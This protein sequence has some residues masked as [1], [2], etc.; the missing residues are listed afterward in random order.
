LK[1]TLNRLVEPHY[2]LFLSALLVFSIISI[3][4]N[5]WLGLLELAITLVLAITTLLRKDKHQKELSALLDHIG[6]DIG[7]AGKDTMLNAPFP[8][9][10]F[11]PDTEELVWSNDPFLAM[12][13]AKEPPFAD[14]ITDLIPG[15]PLDWLELGSDVCPQ[16]QVVNGHRYQVFGR[17]NGGANQKDRL[18]ATFWV[19]VTEYA[20]KRDEFYATRPVVSF[21]IIDNYEEMI[22]GVSET[23]RAD[24]RSSVEEL[25]NDWTRPSHGLLMRYERGRYLYVCEEQYMLEHIRSG[26]APLL[27]GVHSVVS[28]NSINATLSVGIG[29]DGGFSEL[30]DYA[31]L[32][33]DMALSRGGDQAVIKNRNTFTFYGGHAKERE[34]RTK[35]KIRVTAN[36]LEQII[37][38]ASKV[39][40]MGHR[41]GD[42]DCVGAAAGV[43]AI[44]RKKGTTVYF[45]S[46]SSAA[47]GAVL[48]HHLTQEPFYQDRFISPEEAT[49][50]KDDNSILVVVDTNRPSQVLAP[51]LLKKFTHIVVIDHH[52]RASDYISNAVINCH[53]PYASSACELVTEMLEYII[54]PADLLRPE[55]EA[56]LAGIV[57]DTKSFSVR[58]SGRTFEAAAYLR[59]CGAD[60][61]EVKRL[62]QNNLE[63]TIKKNGIIQRSVLYREGIAI[64]TSEEPVSRVI[65]AQ[66][67]DALLNVE[68]VETSFVLY[69]DGDAAIISGRSA[70]DI[71]VQVI[72]EM[73]GGGGNAAAAGAQ[74][75]RAGSL[76]SA[77]SRLQRAIDGYISGRL[78]S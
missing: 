75:P 38:S 3:F 69:M 56:L 61:T 20:E 46:E 11:R 5:L 76:Q 7:A 54:E 65:A 74:I 51:E 41:N 43:A 30:F 29:M 35:V 17:I 40:L 72:L 63:D 57:L 60:T 66:A 12:I 10:L 27:D 4:L 39:F 64:A 31:S 34:L 67:A 15:F 53:E 21:I 13:G 68:G 58:T 14:R 22:R 42:M 2:K 44:C 78:G 77:L 73:L 8:M 19:D 24:I 28:P 23:A 71:N 48:A 62:F 49:L 50:Q 55:A 25:L 70:G 6:N 52:R 33:L 1:Q 18:A 9:A 47:P 26:F 59:R 32:A 16:E 36:A 37:N 45:L